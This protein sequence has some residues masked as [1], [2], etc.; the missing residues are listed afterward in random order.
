[1]ASA[2]G[3]EDPAPRRSADRVRVIV[4]P[5][6]VLLAVGA[7]ALRA[8]WIN[9]RAAA[10]SPRYV[11][12]RGLTDERQP[13]SVWLD[14]GGRVH[15][16]AVKLIGLCENGGSQ[17]LGWSPE[18]P[19]ITFGATAGGIFAREYNSVQPVGGVPSHSVVWTTAR[20]GKGDSSASGELRFQTTFVYP[21]GRRLRCDSGYVPWA[22]NRIGIANGSSVPVPSLAVGAPP[23]QLRFAALVDETCETT[24]EEGAERQLRRDQEDE[25]LMQRQRAVVADHERQYLAIARLGEPSTAV[26]VYR[27]WL[28]NMHERIRLESLAV[29]QRDGGSRKRSEAT[30]AHVGYL[31]IVGNARGEEFGLRV[32]TSNGPL[33]Y[34]ESPGAT[35]GS[36]LSS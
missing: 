21:D 17:P 25:P 13:M 29:L 10:G 30:L 33:T 19:R 5:A 35:P 31:K 15:E 4:Y 22:V 1:M 18:S 32:C 12:L 2:F 36:T 23:T 28:S 11:Q 3:S 20:F 27:D 7:L 24:Y 14:S 8:G 9:T 6:V 26:G 16:L 34:S